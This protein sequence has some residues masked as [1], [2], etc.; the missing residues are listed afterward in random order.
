[1]GTDLSGRRG[2][3]LREFALLR[4][5]VVLAGG[6]SALVRRECFERAGLFD[7]EL[8]TSADWDMWRRIACHYEIE[9]VREPLVLYRLHQS[10]M[11]LNV[12]AFERDVIRAFNHMFADPA[13]IEIHSL[14]RRCYSNLYFTLAGSFLQAGKRNRCLRYL[15]MGLAAWPPN[16][17]YL[18]GAPLRRTWQRIQRKA[19]MPLGDLTS[20]NHSR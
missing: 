2:R 8:S 13:A 16:I 12:E 20:G 4:G 17:A 18:C 3:V 6:S 5:T 7:P 9:V 14:R 15:G 11:H 19:Q 1:L 10:A